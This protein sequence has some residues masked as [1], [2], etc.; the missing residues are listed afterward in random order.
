MLNRAIH[1]TLLEIE[2]PRRWLWLEG[3]TTIVPVTLPTKIVD[4][5]A[6]CSSV[7]S[8]SYIRQAN[9][10]YE[11]L[12]PVN[13]ARVRLEA[14]L[15]TSGGWP[16]MYAFSQ[17]KAYLDSDAVA[18]SSFELIY[19]ART[20]R[21]EET[22]MASGDS[23]PTLQLERAAVIAGAAARVAT[24]FLR[25]NAEHQRQMIAFME[26]IE[27]MHDTENEARSDAFGPSIQPDTSYHDAALGRDGG[28]Y[29]RS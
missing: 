9:T 17:G 29:I 1:Q 6:T 19:S 10:S 23:N 22:A 13:L 15:T 7:T 11:I 20:P 5:P 14:S 3:I 24:T 25:N 2:A 21:N 4:L 12:S 26:M 28:G 8:L 18:G 16:T 27:R